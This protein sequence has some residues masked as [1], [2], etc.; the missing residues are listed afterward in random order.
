MTDLS[1]LPALFAWTI[2]WLLKE[3][4]RQGC[5]RVGNERLA[6]ICN[7]VRRLGRRFASIIA[8]L[9]AGTLRPPGGA[10][11]PP[12]TTR[13]TDGKPAQPAASLWRGRGWLYRLLAGS[14]PQL[15]GMLGTVVYRPEMAE[16]C[17]AAPQLGGVLR[18]LCHMLALRPVP[19]FLK[20]PRR[21]RKDPSPRPS[22][23]RG[24]GEGKRTGRPR[25]PREQAE[26]AI[27]RAL[28]TGKPIDPR[29]LSS[30]A[31]GYVLHPPRNDSCPPPEIGY[32]RSKP[33]PRDYE[34]RFKNLD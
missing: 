34:G 26:H 27:R 33:L 11:R 6:A 23:T 18:S 8:R 7:R 19:G 16:L 22:P 28:A 15:A 10:G 21:V 31:Y 14:A 13:P 1:S 5:A 4:V 25:T 9:E 32:A 29:K 20:L 3:I 17:A 30:V 2:E 24:E 12:G